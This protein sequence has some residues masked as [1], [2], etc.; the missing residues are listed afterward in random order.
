[1]P[2][3][4]L[5][6]AAAKGQLATK[7]QVAKQAERMHADP[8]AKAKL[9]EFLLTW[10]RANHGLDLSKDPKTFPGFDAAAISDLKTSLELFLDDILTSDKADFRQLVL[11]DDVYLNGRLAKFY[12]ADLPADAGFTKL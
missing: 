5:L 8:R 1:L 3:Q 12:G 11:S 10:A 9:R 2:D 4:T 7:E 6:E